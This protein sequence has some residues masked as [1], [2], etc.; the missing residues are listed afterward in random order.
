M[1]FLD[2]FR[3]LGAKPF[4][5]EEQKH[6]DQFQK[7][8]PLSPEYKQVSTR[9]SLMKYDEA[10]TDFEKAHALQKILTE[11]LGLSFEHYKPDDFQRQGN[12]S[13]SM[14]SEPSSDAEDLLGSRDVFGEQKKVHEL[15]FDQYFSK[16]QIESRYKGDP[17]NEHTSNLAILRIPLGFEHAID[18]SQYNAKTVYNNFACHHLL[19]K[20]VTDM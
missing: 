5:A 6:Y 18:F 17:L 10:S 14:G 8:Y 2:R 13:S 3:R 15:N 19:G 12:D 16:Q 4:D 11:S 20:R 9:L 1:F 7:K